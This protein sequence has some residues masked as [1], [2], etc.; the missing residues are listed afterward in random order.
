MFNVTSTNLPESSR[1]NERIKPTDFIDCYSIRSHI[2][3]RGAADIITTFP[4]WAR[5]LLQI[6]GAVV[7]PFGLS[8]EGPEAAD[9]IGIFPVETVDK[10]EIVA[11]FNDKHLNFRV[12]VISRNDHVFLATWVRP[13]NIGGRIYLRAI[14]PFHILI[15]RD[16]LRRVARNSDKR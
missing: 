14:M 8:K 12:S 5:L 7:A 11:G 3:T 16:A 2:T 13:H 4:R 10:H 9:K 15:S 6:R 1:L